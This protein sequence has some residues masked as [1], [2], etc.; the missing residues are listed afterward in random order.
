MK[1]RLPSTPL[2][3]YFSILCCLAFIAAL[4][5][6]LLPRWPRVQSL[7]GDKF[8]NALADAGLKPTL[9]PST[10]PQSNFDMSISNI[11]GYQIANGNTLRIFHAQVRERLKF[12]VR[13]IT[14]MSSSMQLKSPRP[15]AANSYTLVGAIDSK[16]AFQTCVV[17]G[18]PK[19]LSYG[20]GFESLGIAVDRRDGKPQQAPFQI[21]GFRPNRSYDCYLVTVITSPGQD[22]SKSDWDVVLDAIR[23]T[24]HASP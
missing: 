16:P 4:Q 19:S 7:D 21:L 10:E 9:L 12:N 6:I 14:S 24:L 11:L 1:L 22:L 15:Y 2:A 23:S 13:D 17:A 8:Y 5:A 18:V 3:R 20:L